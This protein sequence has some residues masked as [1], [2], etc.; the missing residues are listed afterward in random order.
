M[1]DAGPAVRAAERDAQGRPIERS[2]GVAAPENLEAGP[3]GIGPA[4]P[5]S[6]A[7]R[8]EE[9]LP[10]RAFGGPF[11]DDV[12]PVAGGGEKVEAAGGSVEETAHLHLQDRDGVGDGRAAAQVQL[13]LA[14]HPDAGDRLADPEEVGVERERLLV[15]VLLPGELGRPET[16]EGLEE[17]QEGV[18]LARRRH[19][20]VEFYAVRRAAPVLLIDAR[21]LRKAFKWPERATW[22]QPGVPDSRQAVS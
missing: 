3:G 21:D 15:R 9:A 11:G 7:I 22:G 13:Q 4:Q 5:V 10:G 19:G 17:R 8:R 12:H 20:N 18:G 14:G 2:I 6:P 16:G 1:E